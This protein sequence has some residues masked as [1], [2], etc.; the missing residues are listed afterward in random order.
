MPGFVCAPRLRAAP[1]VRAYLNPEVQSR[2][3]RLAEQQ[4]SGWWPV[5]LSLGVQAESILTSKVAWCEKRNVCKADGRPRRAGRRSHCRIAASMPYVEQSETPVSGPASS[6]GRHAS[7]SRL[8]ADLRYLAR[9]RVLPARVAW[10]VW[11]GRRLASRTGDQFTLVSA[12]RPDDL[13]VLLKL[14]QGRQRI[15]ELGTGTGWT[16]IALALADSARVITTYD[17]I[18]R[19]ERE[20]YAMLVHGRVRSRITFLD[21]P[22]SNGPRDDQFCD[23]LYID[24]SHDRQSTID[25]FQAWLPALR[26]GSIVVFDD[27]THPDFPGV[28]EAV[29]DLGIAGTQHGTLFVHTR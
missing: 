3:N 20:S 5:R 29:S 2:L 4:L 16:A 7:M 9:L 1:L 10:F 11:R 8:I 21:E 13:A 28:R 18:Y 26:N 27:F 22:G 23:L 24:S 17:P 6:E 25:E 14:A 15:V 19:T 12:T